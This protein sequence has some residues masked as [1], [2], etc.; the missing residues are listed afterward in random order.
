MASVPS[1]RSLVPGCMSEK[2]LSAR[3]WLDTTMSVGSRTS[4]NALLR[5]P[6]C[7]CLPWYPIE[8]VSCGG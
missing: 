1:R 5:L 6:Y 7:S 3:I 8:M 4:N 2:T